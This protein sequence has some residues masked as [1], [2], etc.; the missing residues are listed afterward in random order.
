[1]ASSFLMIRDED[2]ARTSSATVVLVV[3]FAQELGRRTA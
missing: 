3:G 2:D 1:M